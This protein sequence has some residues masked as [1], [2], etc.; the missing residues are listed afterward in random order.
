M[1]YIRRR[2]YQYNEDDFRFQYFLHQTLKQHGNLELWKQ[3][4][5]NL[6]LLMRNYGNGSSEFSNPAQQ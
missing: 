5:F 3:Y 6:S 2:I 4:N 1:L